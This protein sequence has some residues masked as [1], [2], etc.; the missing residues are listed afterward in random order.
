MTR[1]LRWICDPDK[2]EALE[3]DLVELYGS[4]VSWRYVLDVCSLCVRQPRTLVRSLAAAVVVLAVIG[5]AQRAPLRYTIRAADP[6]GRFILEFHDGRAVAASLDGTPVA[7]RDLVQTGDTL[8][9]R[10][11]DHGADFIIA[12]TPGGI[13]WHPR[14]SVSP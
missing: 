9:I 12:L 1:L 14:R 10:G 4:R 11:G 8:I 13:A 2:L 7:E 3:G 6:A 5:P